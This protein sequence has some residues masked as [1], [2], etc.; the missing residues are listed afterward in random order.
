MEEKVG[1]GI[2]EVKP[3]DWWPTPPQIGP[4]LPKWMGVTWPWYTPLG[5]E[6]KV[7]DLVISPEEVSPGQSVTISCLV[8]NIGS[9]AGDYTLKLGGDF[10]AEQMVTLEPGESTTVSFTVTPDRV[11]TYSV[12]VDGLSGSFRAT[13]VPVADIRVENLGITPTEVYIGETVTISVTAT[14][15]GAVA[16][17]KRIVCNVT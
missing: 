1:L 14:N 7:S 2:P 16:G 15:Y 5:A 4:P 10:M 12:T 17:T 3:E 6:F 8:K 9:E 11:K 13:E